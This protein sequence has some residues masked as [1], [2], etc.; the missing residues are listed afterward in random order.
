MSIPYHYL[1]LA[2]LLALLL[3]VSSSC[4]DKPFDSKGSYVLGREIKAHMNQLSIPCPVAKEGVK[5]ADMGG[6][7][8][9]DL[10]AANMTLQIGKP[11]TVLYDDLSIK[12]LLSKI[13]KDGFEFSYTTD[14]PQYGNGP[15]PSI[16]RDE[17]VIW[18]YCDDYKKWN[19]PKAK[20]EP[21]LPRTKMVTVE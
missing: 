15:K 12:L 4:I 7:N 21:E 1:S 20:K 14:V 5:L 2:I 8:I 10:S 11:Y 19:E 13:T 3:S 6:V 18:L 16:M 9:E 17:G